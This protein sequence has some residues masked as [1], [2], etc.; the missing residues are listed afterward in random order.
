[1]ATVWT[2]SGS[3]LDKINER[4]KQIESRIEKLNII[5]MQTGVRMG[6]LSLK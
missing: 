2:R 1:M 6:P 3:D 5:K 4:V